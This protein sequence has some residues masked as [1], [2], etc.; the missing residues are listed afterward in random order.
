MAAGV[1]N[2]RKDGG[3]AKLKMVAGVYNI[4]NDGSKMA[5]GV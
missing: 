5:G 1:Y 2:I 3:E 4:K